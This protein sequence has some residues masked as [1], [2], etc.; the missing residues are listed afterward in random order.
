MTWNALVDI[1]L[2][3]WERNV[4]VGIGLGIL[5]VSFQSSSLFLLLVLVAV[6]LSTLP[7]SLS[8][9]CCF[10]SFLTYLSSLI[11]SEPL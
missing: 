5:V 1:E 4:L 10:Q 2:V 6:K 11:L 7:D 9:D 3:I 8:I